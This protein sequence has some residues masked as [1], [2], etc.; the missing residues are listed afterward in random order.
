MASQNNWTPLG[1]PLDVTLARKKKARAITIAA[2]IAVDS[3]VSTLTDS[4][5][6]SRVSW[7]PTSI[8][9]AARIDSVIASVP[10]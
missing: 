10:F 6:Q 5:N 9:A 2:A 3:T 8:V 1:T 4:P 7:A